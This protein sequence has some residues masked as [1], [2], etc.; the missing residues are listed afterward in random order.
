MGTDF[1]TYLGNNPA[2]AGLFSI[3]MS[4]MSDQLNRD[5][6]KALDTADSTVAVDVGGGTGALVQGLLLANR[7]CAGTLRN[8]PTPLRGG[9]GA[10]EKPG[11]WTV[12]PQVPETSSN[13]FR[14]LICTGSKW[15]CTTGAMRSA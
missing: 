10:A 7:A 12:S 1:F 8:C 2:E 15:S 13:P 5:L 14:R 3:A 11:R 9:Q 4:S 6:V